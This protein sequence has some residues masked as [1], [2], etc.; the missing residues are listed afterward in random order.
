MLS[1]LLF[2]LDGTLVNTDP[3]HFVIWQKMLRE[4]GMEIDETFY[5]AQISGGL[6]PEILGRILPQLSPEEIQEFAEKKE[7]IFREIAT[8]LEPLPGVMEALNWG[9]KHKLKLGLVTNAPRANAEFM[10]QT[11]K[12]RDAFDLIVLAEEEAAAKPDPTPY[13]VALERLGV[14]ADTAITFEDSP[15][16]IRAS[17]AAGIKTVG[18]ASTH[19]PDKLMDLGVCMA[20]PDFTDLKVWTLLNSL[21]DTDLD[22]QPSLLNNL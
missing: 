15:S 22:P 18:I 3:V 11:L 2:D 12:L 9:R 1:A 10:L 6:N 17:V 4:Y 13:L 8:S 16:G 7:A 19:D 14:T 21:V 5:Q 20:V